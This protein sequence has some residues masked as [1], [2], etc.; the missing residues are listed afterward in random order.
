MIYL[1][2]SVILFDPTKVALKNGAGC[3]PI[4]G[5]PT[6]ITGRSHWGSG[7]TAELAKFEPVKRNAM[8][9]IV[10]IES[11]AQYNKMRGIET[12]HP[13][14]SGTFAGS[15]IT[16]EYHFRIKDSKIIYLNIT[17]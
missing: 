14:V 8:E 17:G 13:L 11:V 9:K 15:P 2:K 4:T 10:K 3:I 1:F 12:L 5:L 7:K 6:T 16:L